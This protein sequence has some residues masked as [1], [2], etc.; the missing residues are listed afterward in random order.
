MTAPAPET[1]IN[2]TVIYVSLGLAIALVLGAIVGARVMFHR[3]ALTPVAMP[4]LPAPMADSPECTSLID[5]LPAKL[6]HLKRAELAEPAPKGAA[7]WQ[8]VSAASGEAERITLRCGTEMPLQYTE[9]AQTFPLG[10]A[11]WLQVDDFTPGSTMSTWF[12]TD[13]SPV[14]AVT[15]DRER[16][17]ADDI[18]PGLGAESLQQAAQPYHPAPLSQL[19]EGDTSRCEGLLS[20]LPESIAEGYER[21]AADT[22]STAAWVSQGRDP[23]VVRCGVEDPDSY[24]P[25]AQLIQV[26]SIPWFEDTSASTASAS[27][28]YAMGRDAT[29]AASIPQGQGNAAI[30]ALSDAIA[31]HTAER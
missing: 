26:N 14:I 6:A 22:P 17:E 7:A 29:V 5:D 19:A 31:Q 1:Q 8:G 28:L 15:A 3:A 20:A 9:F 12:T 10:D 2:R 18:L 13:R 24:A 27:T 30:T 11:T 4:E 23:V 21:V 16:F 25:G